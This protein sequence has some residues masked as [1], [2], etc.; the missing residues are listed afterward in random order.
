MTL[1]KE[2]II[3]NEDGCQESQRNGEWS[4]IQNCCILE[5]YNTPQ[6]PTIFRRGLA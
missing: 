3:D 1:K 4:L 2:R 5:S 6:G